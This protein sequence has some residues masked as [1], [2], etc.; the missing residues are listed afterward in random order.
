M[1][2]WILNYLIICLN[3]FPQGKTILFYYQ[4]NGITKL[5]FMLSSLSYLFIM[6]LECQA[7][8]KSCLSQKL[9]FSIEFLWCLVGT[10]FSAV[11]SSSYK[12]KSLTLE[13]LTC[14]KFEPVVQRASRSHEDEIRYLV[15]SLVW[16]TQVYLALLLE[17]LLV[18]AVLPYYTIILQSCDMQ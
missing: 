1:L 2:L 9:H 16:V 7:E 6:F 11:K 3:L 13:H 10:V 17:S 12:A 4:Y 14:C 8:F 18:A 15:K 5:F